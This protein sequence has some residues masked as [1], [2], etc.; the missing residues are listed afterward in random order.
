MN[1]SYRWLAAVVMVLA[2]CTPKPPSKLG[3]P[4][5]G[6]NHT[7][8]AINWFMVNR[9]GG[10][11]VGPYGGGGKQNC[12]VLLPVRW[13]PGLKVLVEWEKDPNVGASRYWKER[14]FSEAWHERMADHRAKYTHHSAWVEVAPYD[15]L[16]VVDV[17][18]LP[19]DK[20]AV[21]AVAELPGMKGYPF[22]FP[23]NM[24][25]PATCPAP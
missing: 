6:R 1:V 4:I 11:N 9:N 15:K 16:G 13:Q 14:M 20:I 18:F 23:S 3:A 24:Q 7:G 12:C 2:G 17:H 8:A 22:D 21:S 5:E 25:E 10:P 19:C